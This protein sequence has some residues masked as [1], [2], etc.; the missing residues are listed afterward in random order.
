MINQYQIFENLQNAKKYLV[1]NNIPETDEKFVKLKELLKGNLGYIGTFTKWMYND[2]ESFGKI[3]DT[4]KLLK[5]TNNFSKNIDDFKKLEDLY[6]YLQNFEINRIVDRTINGLPSWTKKYANDELRSLI[7]MNIEWAEFVRRFYTEK[8]GRYNEHSEY[9][10]K[11][12]KFKTYGGWL[13]NETKIYIK[14]LKGEWNLPTILKKISNAN[15][16]LEE[17]V[18]YD[19]V[20][21]KPTM[22]MLRIYNFKTSKKIGSPPW[23]IVSSESMFLSYVTNMTNQYFL[24]DF[25]KEISDK[26]HMIGTTVEASGKI[27]SGHWANDDT[28]NDLTYLDRI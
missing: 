24:W 25:T 17:G 10:T 2:R 28:I 19:I 11:P 5:K 26:R 12:V 9:W 15:P 4:F 21:K 13:V 7:G 23:C 14:N 8:G 22:L 1:N 20:F 16:T 27:T 6:D 18:D 3:E